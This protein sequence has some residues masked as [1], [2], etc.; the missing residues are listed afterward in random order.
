MDEFDSHGSETVPEPEN[1]TVASE[2]NDD[3]PAPEVAASPKKDG[4][5]RMEAYD[6]VQSVVSAIVVGILLFVFIGRTIGVDG[7]SMYPTLHD[8]DRV[9]TSNMFYTPKNGDIVVV[10]VPSF[11]ETP[12]VKRVIAVGGQTIDIDFVTGDVTVDGAVLH[13]PYINELTHQQLE[14]SGPVTVPEGCIF[15]MGDNRNESSDSRRATIGVIDERAILGKVHMVLIPGKNA[16]TGERN[17]ST[18]GSVYG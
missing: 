11:S 3:V 15:V 12:L 8:R 10:K 14:F 5:A 1:D 4:G 18:F 9:I 2:V 13:E 16:V 7:S 17:W 6:W